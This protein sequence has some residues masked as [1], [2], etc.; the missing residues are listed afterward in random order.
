MRTSSHLKV[1][2]LDSATRSQH[3]AESNLFQ[4]LNCGVIQTG[5]ADFPSRKT[6]LVEQ[7]DSSAEQRN[8]PSCNRSRWSRSDDDDIPIGCHGRLHVSRNRCGQCRE[9]VAPFKPACSQS[10]NTSSGVNAPATDSGPSICTIGDRDKIRV[11]ST[12]N[13]Y[14][15]RLRT[16]SLTNTARRDPC[17][18]ERKTVTA[19][20]SSR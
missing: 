5:P 6:F 3:V 1:V 17:D 7:Q 13:K 19:S 16:K 9:I 10:C 8:L 20:A 4:Q 14:P 15:L 12:A 11:P 18:I 2:Q